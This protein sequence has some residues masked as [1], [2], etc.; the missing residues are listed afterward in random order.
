[1][2]K[3]KSIITAVTLSTLATAGHAADTVRGWTVDPALSVLAFGSIKNDY[4]GETHRFSDVTGTV[5]E[6]GNVAITV[7]LASLETMIDIRNERMAEF[8]FQNAPSAQITTELDMAALAALPVGDATMLETYGT[9]SL[10][11]TDTDLDATFFVMRLSE[12]K[13]LVTSDGMIMLATED[14]AFDAGIDKLQ[15]LA[16]LDGITRVSP[17]TLRLVFDAQM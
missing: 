8:V 10:L 12:D 16:S 9:L 11:G 5:D 3:F 4:A 1:M 13:V 17:V 15:E 2:C 7:G 14:T 6:K